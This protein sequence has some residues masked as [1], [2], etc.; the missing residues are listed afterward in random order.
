MKTLII[1]SQ[2]IHNKTADPRDR[3]GIEILRYISD[4][5]GHAFHGFHSVEQIGGYIIG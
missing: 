3:L 2:A 1:K 4:F 5:Q